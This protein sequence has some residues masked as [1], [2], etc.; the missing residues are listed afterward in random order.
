MMKIIVDSNIVFS[1][2]L[3][4]QSN[5][6]DII[7]NAEGDLSFYTCEYLREEIRAHKDKLCKRAHYTDQEFD[8]LE[9]LLYSKITF[10]SESTIP[11]EFWQKA[12]GFVRDID[13]NDIP[14]VT[15]SLFLQLKLWTGDKT[16]INGLQQKGFENII[17][18]QE[19]LDGRK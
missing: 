8:E 18:A 16:L 2:L 14:F 9:Y 12:A 7:F 13:M 19:I 17:T 4:P 6:G 5:I 10:F 1:A 3:D 15:L 11:F